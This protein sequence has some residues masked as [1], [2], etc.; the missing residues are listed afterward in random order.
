MMHDD[1]TEPWRPDP[2]MA[3]ELIALGRP[4][5]ARRQGRSFTPSVLAHPLVGSVGQPVR[6]E[7][8]EEQ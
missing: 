8:E 7:D 1:F 3:E 2:E 4:A 6:D 5:R